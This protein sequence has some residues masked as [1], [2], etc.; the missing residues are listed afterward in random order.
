MPDPWGRHLA[1][2]YLLPSVPP[3]PHHPR[4]A[5]SHLIHLVVE[6][7]PWQGQEHRLTSKREPP[8]TGERAR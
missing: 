2:V 3:E 6:D 7:V 4:L 5:H 1:L 8:I